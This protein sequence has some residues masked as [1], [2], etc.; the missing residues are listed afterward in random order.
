MAARTHPATTHERRGAPPLRHRR[1]YRRSSGAN[2]API[3]AR[4][5]NAQR[6]LAPRSR[7]PRCARR[8]RRCAGRSAPTQTAGAWQVRE[9]RP[10]RTGKVGRHRFGNVAATPGRRSPIPGSEARRPRSNLHPTHERGR[11]LRRLPAERRFASAEFGRAPRQIG[12]W[13]AKLPAARPR[14]GCSKTAAGR[15]VS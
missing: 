7:W 2:R 1:R 5:S 9:T 6:P 13:L 12:G 8:R 10:D 3:R 14:T 15:D 11:R 4:P